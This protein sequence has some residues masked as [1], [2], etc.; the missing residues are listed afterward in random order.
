MTYTTTNPTKNSF[1][2][3]SAVSSVISAFNALSVDEQL[4]LLWVLYE[5]MGRSIT[6]AAP[7][8]ARM[9]FA[10]GLLSQVRA[11]PQQEQLQFMRDLVNRKNT[12]LTR[13]YGVLTNNTKLAFWYQLAEDMRNGLVI[14]VPSYYK[15]TQA[16]SSVFG[17]I[18][19]LDFN[20]QITVLRQVVVAMGVDPIA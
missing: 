14:P 9:Q 16:A 5:N 3:A 20:Q 18:S 11:L 10:E 8:A 13:S 6:P 12:P 17:E 2:S 4:G 19:K 7:G 15:L 1:G